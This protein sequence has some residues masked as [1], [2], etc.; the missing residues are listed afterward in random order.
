MTQRLDLPM[1]ESN[2]RGC[3]SRYGTLSEQCP[4]GVRM[5]D[6]LQQDLIVY[7]FAHRMTGRR[8]LAWFLCPRVFSQ[9]NATRAFELGDSDW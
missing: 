9:A 2:M 5:W 3:V 6:G 8:F 4:L 1:V 7:Q